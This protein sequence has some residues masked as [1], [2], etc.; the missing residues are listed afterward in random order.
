MYV[1]DRIVEPA[2]RIQIR[3]IVHISVVTFSLRYNAEIQVFD[4]TLSIKKTCP[5]GFS[6]TMDLSSF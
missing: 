3:R 5:N 1:P 2:R 6:H 4:P